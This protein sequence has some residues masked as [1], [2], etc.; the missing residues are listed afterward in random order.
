MRQKDRERSS[1]SGVIST[2]MTET[3]VSLVCE[4]KRSKYSLIPQISE[5]GKLSDSDHK[6]YTYLVFRKLLYRVLL[7]WIF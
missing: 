5:D 2:T 4:A 3:I 6:I 7:C 1:L